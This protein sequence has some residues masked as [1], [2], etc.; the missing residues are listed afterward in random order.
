MNNWQ[1]IDLEVLIYIQAH[2]RNI[3]LDYIMI[4]F[5]KFGEL[6]FC[7]ILL[8]LVLLIN[9]KYR[10]V[11]FLTLVAIAL[12]AIVGDIVLKHLVQRP[13]P[14]V[15]W[16]N[17][18]LIIK[19]PQTFSFPS[20]HALSSFAAATVLAKYLRPWAIPL[21]IL[22]FLVAFSRVYL[23]VHYP[24]DVLVGAILGILIGRLV[25]SLAPPKIELMQGQ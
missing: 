18:S 13:R 1:Q 4:F 5:T 22:A 19:A 20:G 24:S 9:K 11:G 12:G 15:A 7:W 21:F 23:F 3:A 25:I 6:G 2:I 14:F 10:R 16:P 17:I 8:S